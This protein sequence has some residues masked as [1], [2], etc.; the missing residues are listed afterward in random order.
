MTWMRELKRTYDVYEHLAGK[1]RDDQPVLLPIAH[2][3]FQAQIEVEL[4]EN[5]EFIDS[6]KVEKDDAKTMIP[7]T[8]DSAAKTNGKWP[9]PLCDKLCYVA[10]D[11]S[12][13]T[14]DDKESYFEAY[15]EQL[16]GWVKSED[17]HFM[18]LA[19]YRYLSKRTLIADLV[20]TQSL[21]LED[22]GR[23]TD[24]YKLQD[25]GQTGANVRFIVYG[26]TDEEPAV[27]KNE[28]I[29]EQ[30]I[31]YYKKK[32]KKIELC[33]VSGD[34]VP[35]TQKHPS[36]IRN[37]NDKAKLISGNDKSGFTYRGRFQ[38]KEQA[39]SVGYEVSQKTHNALR[40]LIEK[41]G[42]VSDESAIV[43]WMTNQEKSVPDLMKDSVNAYQGIEEID[44]EALLSQDDEKDR[45]F[46]SGMRF[47]REFRKAVQGYAAKLQNDDK[48]AVIA[49]ESASKGRLAIVYYE[50]CGAKQYMDTLM[51]WQE[52]CRWRRT[53]CLE[54]KGERRHVTL[55]STPSIKEMV[56][57]AYGI[58]KDKE[59]P[60]LVADARLLR[61]ETRR[62]LM[63]VTNKNMRI[64]AELIK[65][66]A[67]RASYPE[68]MDDFVWKNNVLSVVCAM[69]RYNYE[70]GE[71]R[72]SSFLED[73]ITDRNILFGRLLAICDY[74]EKKA[75]FE[76]DENGKVVEGRM[77]TAKRYWNMY[78]RRPA[79]TYK[80]IRENLVAY[81]KKLHFM[82]LK[83]ME[84][85]TG[86]IMEQLAKCD[87]FDDRPLREGYLPA[88]Y[89]QMEQMK[90]E[91][92]KIYEKKIQ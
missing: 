69:I 36:K 15:L 51:E 38:T 22:N 42:Y 41:Q 48:V 40:W 82:E 2:S 49:L 8:V 84:E 24:E 11:Y 67:R 7:V 50:E 89:L 25:L 32:M 12:K 54:G 43:C 78:S 80:T 88:Y 20:R 35:C 33:Y 17:S 85:W 61:M 81:E 9:H 6:R 90:E 65:S 10:G 79:K 74:M 52:H 55:E 3:F 56:L 44:F 64:P 73:N 59:K 83:I 1:I 71:K 68:A 34:M 66:A 37:S 46:D 53:I 14:G 77:T 72:M 31:K 26:K 28:Q 4:D 63:C 13:Y 62:L 57:A 21:T 60:W 29:Q 45:V 76:R 30:F 70:K 86:Q 87:G 75:M 16:K 5:G 23:L 39:V 58:Q 91:I 18:V 19:V 92:N 47:A 27:W